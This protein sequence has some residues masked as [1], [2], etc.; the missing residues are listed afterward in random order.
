ME[1]AARKLGRVAVNHEPVALIAFDLDRF[2][3]LNDTYGHAVG[4]RV[5][6]AF[7]DVVNTALRPGDLFGRIGGE[8]FACLLSNIS[9]VDATAV[10][11]RIRS[12]FA[13]NEIVI[14]SVKVRATASAGV[15]FA[16]QQDQDLPALMLAADQTLYRAKERGRNR[17]ETTQPTLVLSDEALR[18]L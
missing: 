7:C 17:I 18:S 13:D 2:K 10:A 16:S 8:E 9:Q 4:D 14:G 15:A 12:R 3:T 6:C 11:E 1:N 5:L